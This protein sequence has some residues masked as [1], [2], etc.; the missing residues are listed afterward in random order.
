MRQQARHRMSAWNILSADLPRVYSTTAQWTARDI[1][2]GVITTIGKDGSNEIFGCNNRSARWHTGGSVGNCSNLHALNLILPML[3]GH[4]FF[5]CLPKQKQVWTRI[6]QRNIYYPSFRTIMGS[7][8]VP[9]LPQ[10]QMYPFSIAAS[11][12]SIE[13][14]AAPITAIHHISQ[15]TLHSERERGNSLL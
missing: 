11:A 8:A 4:D 15:K 9:A 14:P 3:Y 10:D 2:A 13:E 6:T 1:S 7:L 5:S 12:F